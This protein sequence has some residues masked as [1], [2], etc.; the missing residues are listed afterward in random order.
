M[1]TLYN[2]KSVEVNSVVNKKVEGRAG[3]CELTRGVATRRSHVL[4]LNTVIGST[5]VL[6]ANLH[7]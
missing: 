3:L 4:F 7:P 6:R 5:G 1:F 2:C